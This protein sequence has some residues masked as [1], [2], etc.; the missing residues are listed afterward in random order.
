MTTDLNQEPAGTIRAV[1]INLH[2]AE[3]FTALM[4]KDPVRFDGLDPWAGAEAA[5]RQWALTA[6]RDGTV[7]KTDFTVVYEDGFEYSGCFGLK[8]DDT[9]LPGHIRGFCEHVVAHRQHYG[10]IDVD[11]VERFLHTHELGR[12]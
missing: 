8:F 4:T 2:R 6:P 1:R 3:G 10:H 9:D 11:A 5:L 12:P 7:D